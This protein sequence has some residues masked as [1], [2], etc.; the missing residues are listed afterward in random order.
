M[1]K[2][3]FKALQP[4][5]MERLG[6]CYCKDDDYK[7]SIRREAEISEQL[8]ESLSEEQAA[9]AEEYHITE[10]KREDVLL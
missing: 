8:R 1:E 4:D 6:E 5:L 10:W 2:N 9:L 3:I 7:R